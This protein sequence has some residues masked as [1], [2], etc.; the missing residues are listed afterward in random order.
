MMQE[1]DLPWDSPALGGAEAGCCQYENEGLG[2]G[3]EK[4]EKRGRG[5]FLTW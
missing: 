3:E 1:T 2:Y 5:R 4:E